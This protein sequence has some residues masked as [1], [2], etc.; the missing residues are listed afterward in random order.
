M[1]HLDGYVGHLITTMDMDFARPAT[2]TNSPLSPFVASNPELPA[3]R[4]VPSLEVAFTTSWIKDRKSPIFKLAID[5]SDS[6]CGSF[7]EGGFTASLVFSDAEKPADATS[8][9]RWF[10]EKE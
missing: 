6:I 5:S 8:F 7:G 3:S 10:E 1:R 2:L 9:S 4:T